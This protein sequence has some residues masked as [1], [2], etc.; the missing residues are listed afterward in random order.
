M[1]LNKKTYISKQTAI[2][3]ENLNDIQDSIIDLEN[4][5]LSKT[6][7]ESALG[8]TPANQTALPTKVSDLENDSEFVTKSYVDTA[9][10]KDWNQNEATASDYIKN[11]PFYEEEVAE[12]TIVEWTY[13][14]GQTTA[15]LTLSKPL[16]EGKTYLAYYK[17][18]VTEVKA[19]KSDSNVISVNFYDTDK[20]T[21]I[22]ALTM[23]NTDS[24]QGTYS[25]NPTKSGSFK[26]VSPASTRIVHLPSKYIEDMYY[27]ETT[28]SKVIYDLSTDTS[29]SGSLSNQ[30]VIYVSEPITLDKTYI[31]NNRNMTPMGSDGNV[32]LDIY[33]GSSS[34]GI[35]TFSSEKTDQGYKGVISC[36]TS[37][38]IRSLKIIVSASTTIHKIPDKFL[39]DFVSTETQTLTDAQKTQARENI[40]ATS[41]DDIVQPD[42]SQNDLTAKDY[43]KNRPGG[44]V[45]YTYEK[46]DA[47][48]T[49]TSA[50]LT[51]DSS[52]YCN[53]SGTVYGQMMMDSTG[54]T[55]HD[56]FK[57][58]FVTGDTYCITVDGTDYYLDGVGYG[59]NIGAINA[60]SGL[61]VEKVTT[62]DNT[63]VYNCRFDLCP[64]V[65]V[66][67]NPYGTYLYL[68][69]QD[70]NTHSVVISKA[71]KSENI[72]QIPDK[73]LPVISPNTILSITDGSYVAFNTELSLTDEQKTQAREN[74]SIAEYVSSVIT[75]KQVTSGT[76][77]TLEDNAEYR[78]N[79]ITSLSLS[80]PTTNFECWMN[81]TFATSGT[82]SVSFPTGTKYIGKA[83][84]FSNGETWEVSIKDKVVVAA[85]VGDEA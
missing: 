63:V 65:A 78:L 52:S 37:T 21:N 3:A 18:V 74:I 66:W 84:E 33:N 42:Y 29:S 41:I 39:P 64:I 57:T 14:P 13:S 38:V 83:P 2:T 80:Y 46:G 26:L 12:E 60:S 24:T 50:Q 15:V 71:T 82:I 67:A 32:Q 36:G 8:Y 81:L 61:G 79:N 9:S 19:R 73:F 75:K 59:S 30:S 72:V 35:V 62:T 48:Y 55:Y 4:K 51:A 28:E 5:S 70:N 54:G 85:K 6:E 27:Q 25:G 1:S 47:I 23:N 58:D 44:Y 56:S 10:V 69:A 20:T 40:G 31:V 22:G 77:F 16:E 53:N 7:V 17:S 34:V 68:F 43:I 49:N 45:T 76:S 11:R